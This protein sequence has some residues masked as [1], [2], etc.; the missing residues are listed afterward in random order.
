MAVWLERDQGIGGVQELGVRH[1][2]ERQGIRL[3]PAAPSKTRDP[4]SS[5]PAATAPTTQD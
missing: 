2:L 5:L 4:V 1:N 3:S